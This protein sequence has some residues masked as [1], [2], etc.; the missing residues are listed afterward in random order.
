ML[1]RPYLLAAAAGLALLG[2]AGVAEGGAATTT[3]GVVGGELT[4]DQPV[5]VVLAA[6]RPGDPVV[7]DLGTAVVV[8][9]RGSGAGWRLRVAA[10]GPEAGELS[11][12][13]VRLESLAGRPPLNRIAYPLRVPFG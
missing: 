5:A 1:L 12:T 8:D 3:A 6:E 13:E 4:L 11:V 9:A 10:T 7:G 2:A